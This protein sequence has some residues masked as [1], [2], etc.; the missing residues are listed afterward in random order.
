M[1]DELQISPPGVWQGIDIW[2]GE[3]AVGVGRFLHKGLP[4]I[5]QETTTGEGIR[6]AFVLLLCTV[7][8]HNIQPPVRT[9]SYQNLPR[10][11]TTFFAEV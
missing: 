6:S 3:K 5:G 7:S 10:F 8:A 2:A 9:H 4:L 1:R 11:L